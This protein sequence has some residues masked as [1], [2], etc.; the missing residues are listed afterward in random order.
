V[1]KC[2]CRLSISSSGWV[3]VVPESLRGFFDR[4][5]LIQERHTLPC[6]RRREVIAARLTS[7]AELQ[8]MVLTGPLVT[9][10]GKVRQPLGCHREGHDAL[11][12]RSPASRLAMVIYLDHVALVQHSR[13][14]QKRSPFAP[15]RIQASSTAFQASGAAWPTTTAEV[16]RSGDKANFHSNIQSVQ[17]AQGTSRSTE[18]F[19]RMPRAASQTR[20]ALRS[21]C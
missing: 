3:G 20:I 21:R 10:V 18:L 7:P 5:Y 6:A 11:H 19:R 9:Y 8:N 1:K 17:L 4:L 16:P 13:H 12:C 14:E 2:V 15:W